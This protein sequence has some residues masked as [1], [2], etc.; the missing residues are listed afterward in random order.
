[1]SFRI[2]SS[3][4]RAWY[5]LARRRPGSAPFVSGDTF[6]G[7]AD[8]VLE[9]GGRIESR[10]VRRGEVV[11][12]EARELSTF[13]QDYLPGIREPFVLI[14]HN[15]D[16]NVDQSH[17][18]L[19][20]DPRIIRWFAQNALLR[21]PKVTGI[22][23]GLENRHLH[24]N[25]VIRDYE[26][27]LRRASPKTMRILYGFTLGT[28]ASERKPALSALRA[29]V[30]ADSMERT[31]S[32]S[33]RKH[34]QRYGFVASPAGNG[35]DCHRTWEALYLR[36]IPVVRRSPLYESFPGLPVLAVDDWSELSDWDSAFLKGRYEE[37]SPEI[38]TTPYLRF[39]YWRDLIERARVDQPR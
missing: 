30:I 39:D 34:L 11:F 28:N 25:G 27:L 12:V 38:D 24:A 33:Y 15:G 37:I 22:P 19:A 26:L 7:V 3:V 17:L 16:L 1:M 21:H 35:A 36:T 18:G 23:I 2:E 14:T 31:N 8:H 5:R 32:R 13:I 6:R 9:R 20:E 29:S 4:M 10:R